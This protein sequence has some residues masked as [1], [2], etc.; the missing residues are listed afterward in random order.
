[1]MVRNEKSAM[2]DVKFS[3]QASIFKSESKH[4]T[5]TDKTLVLVAIEKGKYLIPYR[6]QKSSPS[7]PMVLYA[8][9]W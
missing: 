7:S 3:D 1:M 4:E 6:T 9:V 2:K 5:T 8:R